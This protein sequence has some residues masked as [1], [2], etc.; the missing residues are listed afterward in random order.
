[1][2]DIFIKLKMR[3]KEPYEYWYQNEWSN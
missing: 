3:G 1:M 2:S